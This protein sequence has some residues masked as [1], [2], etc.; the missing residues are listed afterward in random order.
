MLLANEDLAEGVY[1]DSGS[2]AGGG[3]GRF[4]NWKVGCHGIQDY[5]SSHGYARFPGCVT[6]P[7]NFT[8]EDYGAFC[9]VTLTFD[10]PLK[11]AV[12]E[13]GYSCTTSGSSVTV[14]IPLIDSWDGLLNLQL[15]G[16]AVGGISWDN[17][18]YFD[19]V[20]G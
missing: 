3:R 16:D 18:Y 10:R 5:T 8:P 9:T 2:A 14:T 1:A 20:S 19:E 6:T 11:N 15:Y 13:D 4:T 7:E 17:K 12:S